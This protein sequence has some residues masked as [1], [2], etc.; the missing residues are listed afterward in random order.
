ATILIE[1]IDNTVPRNSEVSTPIGMR[2]EPFRQQLAEREA[3]NEGNRDADGRDAQRRSADRSHEL[4][5]GLHPGQQQQ[6]Q[7]AELRNAVEHRFLFGS[8]RKESCC[9]SGHS[10][11]S[12]EGPSMMPPSSMPMTEG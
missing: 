11:P 10:A 7:N 2:Q 9:S 6:Q 8:A 12:T 5:V 1:E 3:A 4:E